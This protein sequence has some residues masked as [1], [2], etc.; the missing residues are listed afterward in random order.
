MKS[1]KLITYTHNAT[2]V[3][4]VWFEISKTTFV[5]A[6]SCCCYYFQEVPMAAMGMSKGIHRINCFENAIQLQ[7]NQN[8]HYKILTSTSENNSFVF[9]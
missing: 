2:C 3:T 5:V 6:L 9:H 4:Q 7:P 8:T 1:L